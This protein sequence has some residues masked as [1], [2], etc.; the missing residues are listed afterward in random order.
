MS[1]SDVD[2][3]DR[4]TVSLSQE[5]A[6]SDYG[7]ICV[8]PDNLGSQWLNFE[9]G[10]ISKSLDRASVSPFLYGI[11]SSAVTGPLI[12]FQ[13]TVYNRPDVFKLVKSINSSCANPIPEVRLLSVFEVWWPRLQIAMDK[14]QTPRVDNPVRSPEDMLA[15]LV[16]LVRALKKSSHS[17]EPVASEASSTVPGYLKLDSK[18]VYKTEVAYNLARLQATANKILNSPDAKNL[19]VVDL[20]QITAFVTLLRKALTPTLD[21]GL[22]ESYLRIAEG[23]YMEELDDSSGG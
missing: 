20:A 13:H 17:E 22:F 4:W 12:Q 23:R 9:A 15:E 16:D 1:A 3:G 6:E 8:T 21:K 2:K 18:F 11:K 19:D 14:V 10:A 5:L 7:V